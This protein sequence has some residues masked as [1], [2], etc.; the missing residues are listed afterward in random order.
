MTE[1]I[2][3]PLSDLVLLTC[4]PKVKNAAATLWPLPGMAASQ[5]WSAQSS[6]PFW[7]DPFPG[8]VPHGTHSL[9]THTLVEKCIIV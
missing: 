6:I 8:L 5:A 3:I 2:D 4:N 1:Y 7:W 9:D